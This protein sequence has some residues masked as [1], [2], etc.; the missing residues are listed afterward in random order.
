MNAKTKAPKPAAEP[1]QATNTAADDAAVR[2]NVV[3]LHHAQALPVVGAGVKADAVQIEPG[4]IEHF[5][6]KDDPETV[7]RIV[8]VGGELAAQPVGQE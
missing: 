8:S 4:S 5:V 2:S 1:A 7:L 6:S 3:H